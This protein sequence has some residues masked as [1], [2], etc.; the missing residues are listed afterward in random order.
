M[1]EESLTVVRPNMLSSITVLRDSLYYV[2]DEIFIEW[3]H[4][5][6]WSTLSTRTYAQK[7]LIS[8]NWCPSRAAVLSSAGDES[9]AILASCLPS[10]STRSYCN[11]LVSRCLQ[12]PDTL[13]A[14]TEAKHRPLC[15]GACTVVDVNESKLVKM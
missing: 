15:S 3:H 2:C 1:E 12:L 7:A 5:T 13:N 10:P 9:L 6:I 14:M 4:E 8:R 11:C